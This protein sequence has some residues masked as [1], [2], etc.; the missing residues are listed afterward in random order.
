[1]KK[2]A[3]AVI[4]AFTFMMASCNPSGGVETQTVQYS[5]LNLVTDHDNQTSFITPSVYKFYFNYTENNVTV[6][7]ENLYINNSSNGFASEPTDWKTPNN[8]VEIK[9]IK[10]NVNDNSSTP[11]KYFNCL[12]TSNINYSEAIVNGNDID[13]S[14]VEIPGILIQYNIGDQYTVKTIPTVSFYTG[15]TYTTFPG[16]AG[17]SNTEMYYRVILDYKNNKAQVTIFEARFAEA[18][19]KLTAIVLK[20]LTLSADYD[21]Y[22]ITGKNI[23][24][25]SSEGNSVTPNEKYI[26][27]EFNMTVYGSQLTDANITYKV[28]GN[29]TGQFTGSYLYTVQ[30]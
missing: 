27:N 26:F 5:R 13:N 20:D 28:A 19:P 9:D 3:L 14:T 12:L 16:G 4:P 23:I 11:V 2:L 21:G 8:D 17:F 22:T 15:S 6:S 7:C 18:M 1:M 10:A 24:P 30:Q 29:L 25:L